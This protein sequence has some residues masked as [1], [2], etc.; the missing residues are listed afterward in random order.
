MS[1]RKQVLNRAEIVTRLEEMLEAIRTW[2]PRTGYYDCDDEV[3]RILKR[4]DG[5]LDCAIWEIDASDDDYNRYPY[6][7]EVDPF[8][9]RKER[10]ETELA[11]SEEE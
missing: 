9:A 10:I 8:D 11:R 2:I 6:K 3:E 4:L 7:D 5:R 1:E